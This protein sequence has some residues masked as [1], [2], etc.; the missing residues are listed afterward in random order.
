M[1]KVKWGILSTANIA[2]T[3]LV[4]AIERAVNAEVV[5]IASRGSKVH[6]VAQKLNI[7]KAYESYEELLADEEVEVIYIPLPNNLHKEWAMKAAT[8]GKHV[9]CEKPA[10]LAQQDLEEIVQHFE[11]HDRLF[12]EAFMYQFHPQHERVKDIVNSGEIGEVK[13]YKSSHS[14]YFENSEGDIRMNRELGGG[15]LWD[16]GCYSLHALQYHLGAEVKK[17]T[18]RAVYDEGTDV[19]L[20]AFGIIELEN[21]VTAVIDCS[22][23]MVGRNTYEIIGTKGSIHVKNAFRPDTFSGDAQVVVTT[24]M[25]ERTEY[26]QG[27]I[28]KLEVEYFSNLVITSGSLAKQHDYSRNTTKLLLQGHESLKAF[29]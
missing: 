3:Q 23:D 27:D 8:A 25:Q 28:Y 2:V 7:Q 19:D 12:M 29:N 15:A 4:P 24:G 22:F 1:V 20:S 21:D 18:F 14:F 11:K 5:A 10:V 13:F 6:A 26:V 17:M 9:L 16:V